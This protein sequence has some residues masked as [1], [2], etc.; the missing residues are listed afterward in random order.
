MSDHVIKKKAVPMGVE[1]DI[2]NH[3]IIVRYEM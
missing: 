2:D 1:P 3:S